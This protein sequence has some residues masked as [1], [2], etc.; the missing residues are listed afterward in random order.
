MPDVAVDSIARCRPIN[1]S[2]S[3]GLNYW[4]GQL[5]EE[6][7]VGRP[8]SGLG[9]VGWWP[10]GVLGLWLSRSRMAGLSSA[11][12]DSL[13][14]ESKLILRLVLRLSPNAAGPCWVPFASAP[15]PG[16]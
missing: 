5:L 9:S 13:G 10:G 16:S 4:A 15:S 2:A 12:I 8:S 3:V 14:G 7:L 1:G 11:G 6:G